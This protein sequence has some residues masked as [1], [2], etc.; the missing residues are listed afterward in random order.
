MTSSNY[1][2]ISLKRYL[3]QITFSILCVFT[4]GAVN[5]MTLAESTFD[6]GADFDGWT[7]VECINAGLCPL[8][9]EVGPLAANKFFH[10]DS[11]PQAFEAGPGYLEIEDPNSGSTGLYNAPSKFTSA[12]GPGTILEYDMKIFGGSF[13]NGASTDVPILYIQSTSAAVGLL[14]VVQESDVP[15]GDWFQMAVPI[16]ANGDPLAGPGEWFGFS[17]SGLSPIADDGTAFDA[18]FAGPDTILRILGEL[19]K[20]DLDIDGTRID[21]I[22]LTAVPI[23]AAFPMMLSALAAFG[24]WRRKA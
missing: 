4:V 15:I 24:V 7:G 8:T 6:P 11:D 23:P 9:G 12:I 19:T 16:V 14:Y 18:T 20:D 21:N 10:D 3:T 13:D 17:D 1:P 5:A 2:K 22:R